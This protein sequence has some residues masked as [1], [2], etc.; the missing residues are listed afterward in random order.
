M[1]SAGYEDGNDANSLRRDPMFKMALDL[2]PIDRELCSQS[3]ASPLSMNARLLRDDG[4]GS[5][6]ADS[7]L[8]PYRWAIL[9]SCALPSPLVS[10][11]NVRFLANASMPIG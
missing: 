1:I 11:A 3:P 5:N 8:S 2:S 7:D 9:A 4:G 10:A 6:E